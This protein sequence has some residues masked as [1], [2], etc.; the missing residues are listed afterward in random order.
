MGQV[1]MGQVLLQGKTNWSLTQLIMEESVSESIFKQRKAALCN[2]KVGQN[3]STLSIALK[4]A[5]Q[6]IH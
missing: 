2:F 4:L 1:G 6:V 3:I 5:L